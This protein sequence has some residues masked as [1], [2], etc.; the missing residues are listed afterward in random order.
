MKYNNS[1]IF[2]SKWFWIINLIV[3]FIH[4]TNR[5][6]ELGS[7]EFTLKGVSPQSVTIPTISLPYNRG[8]FAVRLKEFSLQ[9]FVFYT[10]VLYA[11]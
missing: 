1:F 7:S 8:L 11:V 9:K 4:L 3:S 10:F 5:S 6:V 2:M